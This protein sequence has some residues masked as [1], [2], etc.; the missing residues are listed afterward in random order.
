MY[1][2]V[3]DIKREVPSDVLKLLHNM[4]EE[5][6][7]N[8]E[9]KLTNVSNDPYRFIYEGEQ[10]Y[11]GCLMLGILELGRENKEFVKNVGAWEWVDEDPHECSDVLKDLA[12]PVR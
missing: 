2:T 7:D 1:Q 11:Y 3:I 9:G 5:A 6:F 4:A 10:K 8:R 12:E